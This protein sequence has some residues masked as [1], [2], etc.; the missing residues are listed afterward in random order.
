MVQG[1]LM[2]D[3]H[4]VFLQKKNVD[5]SKKL[6]QVLK[7]EEIKWTQIIKTILDSPK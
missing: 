3:P 5:L 7:L 6:N 2:N 1:V 4:N